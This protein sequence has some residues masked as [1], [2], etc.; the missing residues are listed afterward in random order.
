[1]DGMAMEV[2]PIFAKSRDSV[3]GRALVHRCRSN[4]TVGKPTTDASATP[5]AVGGEVFRFR[6]GALL[7]DDAV[8]LT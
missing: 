7:P 6:R 5:V 3:V 8:D 4:E 1:M 2:M